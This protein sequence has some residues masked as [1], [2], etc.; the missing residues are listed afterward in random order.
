MND[1][2]NNS[3]K[4][5]NLEELYQQ[6]F[7]IVES[8]YNKIA[9]DEVKFRKNVEKANYL[10]LVC[11]PDRTRFNRTLK[12]LNSIIKAIRQ[13]LRSNNSYDY[14]IID[15]FPLIYN[16][17]GRVHFGHRLRDICT[18]GYCASKKEKYYG[19]KVHV[20]TSLDGNPIDF[21]VT[22][23]NTDDKDAVFEL[24]ELCYLQNL[25]ADKGYAKTGFYDTV[26][27]S[28]GTRL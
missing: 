19:L 21:I 16:K 22:L 25:F 26:K 10:D 11:Y 6:I 18:Y 1:L 9:P 23:T 7:K 17:F 15:S 2:L 14:A 20:I 5:K 12:N 8:L 3:T 27:R 13:E 24:E 28:T 4:A